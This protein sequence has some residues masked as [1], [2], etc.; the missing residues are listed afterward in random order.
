MHFVYYMNKL[1]TTKVD[2]TYLGELTNNAQRIYMYV[3]WIQGQNRPG[4]NPPDI[5]PRTKPPGQNPSV[6]TPLTKPPPPWTT[7]PPP[8]WTNSP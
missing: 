2:A 5:T 6:E 3:L 4:Q 1:I 7:P 8:P